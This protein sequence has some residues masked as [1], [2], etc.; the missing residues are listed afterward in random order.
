MNVCITWQLLQHKDLEH[1]YRFFFGGASMDMLRPCCP[2][3]QP[4]IKPFKNPTKIIKQFAKSTMKSSQRPTPTDGLR[5]SQA[6]S[7]GATLLLPSA[8]LPQVGSESS[9]AN[10]NDFSSSPKPRRLLWFVSF[11]VEGGVMGTNSALIF[12]SHH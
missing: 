10:V 6:S 5:A 7:Q 12:L 11:F 3:S 4:T 8:T 2:S 9:W 1:F